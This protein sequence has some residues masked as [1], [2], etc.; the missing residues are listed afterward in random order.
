M[1]S[2]AAMRANPSAPLPGTTDDGDAFAVRLETEG[3]VVLDG[4]GFALTSAEADLLDPRHGD[5]RAKNISLGSGGVR[6]AAEGDPALDRL[7]GLMARYCDWARDTLCEL[8]P[9]YRPWLET[10]R[11]SLRT[12]DVAEGARSLRKDDRRLH[13][14]AFASQPT[15]GRRILRVFVNVNPHGEARVW[16]IG[17]DFEAHA[18]RFASSARRL[19]PGEAWLLDTLGVTRSRRTGYDQL[20]LQIHDGAKLSEPYQAS[21]PAREVDFPAGAAWIVYSDS[22]VHAAIAGRFA[23]EQTFYIPLEAMAA[24]EAAP[25]RVLERIVR[26]PLLPAAA[27]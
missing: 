4:R 9:R 3:L 7:E 17:E 21:A 1:Y 24:P 8:A 12:R 26:R 22:V 16:R 25:A 14:D 2:S 10:G 18:R 5:G 27:R 13:V 23:L 19:A 20:M 6:G 11:T 15:G